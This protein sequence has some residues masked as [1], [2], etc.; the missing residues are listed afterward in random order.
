MPWFEA[1][2]SRLVYVLS[3]A[4]AAVN[5]RDKQRLRLRGAEFEASSAWRTTHDE[6]TEKEGRSSL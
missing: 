6:S 3:E 4:P 1:K 5:A 2:R